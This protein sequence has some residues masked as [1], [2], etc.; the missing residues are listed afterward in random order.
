[1]R[2]R[3]A[4]LAAALLAAGLA[5]AEEPRQNVQEA[6]REALLRYA[7]LPSTPPRLPDR[8]TVLPG[9]VPGMRQGPRPTPPRG[10]PPHEP[11]EPRTPNGMHD[12]RGAL[13][14]HGTRDGSAMRDDMRASMAQAAQSRT[15][16][17]A[18]RDANALRGDAAHRSSMGLGMGAMPG[19]T[20]Q[21]GGWAG[22]WGCQDGAG[23]WRTM[24]PNGGMMGGGWS[25][26]G[27]SGGMNLL[28][29]TPGAS[30]TPAPGR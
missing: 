16:M 2:W 22:N 14:A 20:G 19:M 26:G 10:S 12:G 11:G 28:A 9:S 1:M 4:I 18:A 17:H 7:T 13:A 3:H 27:M 23:M 15:M 29:P 6:M 24:N 5:R 21:Q 30:F 8:D 25:G